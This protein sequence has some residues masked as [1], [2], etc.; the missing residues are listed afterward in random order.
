MDED[1]FWEIVATAD[2]RADGPAMRRLREH[3]MRIPLAEAVAFSAELIDKLYALDTEELFEQSVFDDEE[4]IGRQAEPEEVDA[5]QFVAVRCAVVLAGPQEYA[6]VLAEP[7]AISRRAW[8]Q[9]WDAENLLGEADGA[10]ER[11]GLAERERP[12]QLMAETGSNPRGF[13]DVVL[14]RLDDEADEGMDA[15][16]RGRFWVKVTCLPA[17]WIPDQS[18]PTNRPRARARMRESVDGAAL[19]V[20]TA[21]VFDAE[22]EAF[23]A[24]AG[25]EKVDIRVHLDGQGPE[26]GVRLR[27]GPGRLVV[28]RNAPFDRV[29]PT[30]KQIRALVRDAGISALD[31]A[32]ERI[33]ARHRP[34]PD[35]PDRPDRRD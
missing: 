31:A 30:R 16:P 26:F 15:L 5:D 7:Q 32:R 28:D 33:R 34:R 24:A 18:R 19:R 11:R 2:G 21:L 22:R 20:G 14:D 4:N 1:R 9:M 12:D 23:F 10:L 27:V 8:P 3:L 35:R 17:G 13:Q 29:N 25:Y 6:R